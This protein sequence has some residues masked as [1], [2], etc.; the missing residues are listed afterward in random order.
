M[1]RLVGLIALLLAALLV[2]TASAPVVA[3]D[4]LSH[5]SY[6]TPFPNGDRYRVVVLGDGEADGLW[7]GLYRTYEEDLTVDV[8]NQSKKWT[9]FTDP[10]RYDW[11]GEIDKILNDG[12]YHVAVVQFGLGEHKAIREGDKVLNV[13]TEEWR[14]AYGAR[15]ETFIR[16]LRAAGLGVYWVGLPVMR[17][18]GQRTAAER[19]NDVFREKAFVNGAKFIDTWSEFA[20]ENGQYTLVGTDEEGRS[21]RMRDSD[22][23]TSRGNLKLAQLVSKE[24]SQ[25][26]E[27]AKKERD[28]P[29][30]G[31]PEE[32]EKVAKGL[33]S[34][35]PATQT[36][37]SGD[38]ADGEEGDALRQDQVG[39]VSV[40]RPNRGA[41]AP[42]DDPDGDTG[43]GGAL[44][45]QVITSSLPG[46]YTA[47]SSISAVSDVTLSSSRPQLPLA[48]RPYYRVLVRGEQLEPKSGRA[49]DFAW[50]PS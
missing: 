9:G 21:Q 24:L 15:V 13:G 32:Q 38:P 8:L 19:L 12:S 26:I 34:P 43:S 27:L 23:F 17:S 25:D 41:A 50:P 49:D 11:N 29:L 7:S 2:S 42:V 35:E 16:K 40:V 31:D 14:E 28:I 5:R 44:D 47:I 22:G 30:A 46:G 45:P 36:A 48:Q 37:V 4:A 18:A 33:T 1:P 10:K 39:D 3:Q 6:I 20:D